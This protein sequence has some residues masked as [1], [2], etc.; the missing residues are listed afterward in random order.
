MRQIGLLLPLFLIAA[1][2]CNETETH[3]PIFGA[4]LPATNFTVD[5]AKDT[6]LKTPGGA[7]ISIPAGS[8]QAGD[9]TSVSLEVKEAYTTDD[10]N[11]G[12][13]VHG[14]SDSLTSNGMI[15]V[16]VVGGQSVSINKPLNISL[17]VKQTGSDIMVYKGI[18][19]DDLLLKWT[20]PRPLSSTPSQQQPSN[21]GKGIFE[22][23]CASCHG[24]KNESTGP[25]L[26]WITKRRDRQWLYTFTR[27][28][29]IMLWRGDGYSCYLFNRY[30]TPMPLFKDLSDGDLASLYHYIDNASRSIDSN[31]VI[32]HKRGF[33]SCVSNDPNCSAVANHP[34]A[35]AADGTSLDTASATTAEAAVT[36]YYTFSIDKHG[37]YNVAGKGGSATAAIADAFPA[38]SDSLHATIQPLQACPCWCSEAAYRRADSLGRGRPAKVSH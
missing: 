17:P 1:W 32:D 22:T 2:S 7:L 21:A 16:N 25:A 27:N 6:V 28:N 4:E 8:L 19:G 20:D 14:S 30:K 15:Y 12:G 9:A 37:W 24:G 18:A 35:L 23:R 36:D 3:E 34:K 31:G 11:R 5:P 33:D 10:M 26:A 13:L 38:T 29:A